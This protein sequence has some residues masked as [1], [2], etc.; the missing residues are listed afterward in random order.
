MSQIEFFYEIELKSVLHRSQYDILSEQLPLMM[1]QTCEDTIFTTRY[2]AIAPDGTYMPGDLRLR[3]SDRI[4]EFVYKDGEPTDVCRREIVAP[5]KSMDKLSNMAKAFE[6]KG[7]V[8]A[9]SWKKH[10]D[11]FEFIYG[12]FEYCVCIQDIVGFAHIL[13]VEHKSRTPDAERHL[14]NL[15]AIIESLGLSVCD[16]KEF[17]AMIRNYVQS[18]SNQTY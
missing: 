1:H 14:P 16:P 10:K 13:E 3:H 2:R 15:A 12:G 18:N 5:L 4:I 8:A 11:E 17:A 9:P 6:R 7:L